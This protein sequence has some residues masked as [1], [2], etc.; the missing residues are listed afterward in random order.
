MQPRN[1]LY[2]SLSMG[3]LI[4]FTLSVF[5]PFGTQDFHHPRKYALLA[6]YGLVVALVSFAAYMLARLIFRKKPAQWLVVHEMF[7]LVLLLF[8]S[9]SACYFYHRLFI[10]GRPL[11]W[12]SYGFFLKIGFATAFLPV[13]LLLVYRLVRLP[14]PAPEG[15]AWQDSLVLPG[16]ASGELLRL[17]LAAFR[18]FQA[19][20][21]YVAVHYIKNGRLEKVL[22][23]G[24][25]RELVQAADHAAVV[26]V[27]R[28]Y[29]VNL[30]AVQKIKGN[31]ARASL[32]LEEVGEEIPVSRSY[33][34]EVKEKIAHRPLSF[35]PE[36]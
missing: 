36:S 17:P 18:Y 32:S 8:L 31:A 34:S 16:G 20:D 7:A 3:L 11:S 13:S 28:S 24:S 19:A 1:M 27:H 4:F 14:Q 35:T 2:V 6:G 29:A 15:S 23:R 26:Q 25:L 9:V 5:Q 33:F 21:N 12:D 22:I 30:H 10:V